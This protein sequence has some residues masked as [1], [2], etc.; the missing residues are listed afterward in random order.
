MYKITRM[1]YIS[2]TNEIVQGIHGKTSK[3]REIICKWSKTFEE[4]VHYL[5]FKVYDVRLLL[6]SILSILFG[7]RE[8]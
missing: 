1:R 6:G 5:V 8:K 3:V 2:M 7:G 4:V